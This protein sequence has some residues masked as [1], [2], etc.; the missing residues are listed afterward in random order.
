MMICFA[1][2]VGERAG[3]HTQDKKA[4]RQTGI[5]FSPN[6]S[7][8]GYQREELCHEVTHN[9]ENALSAQTV[10][11]KWHDVDKAARRKICATRAMHN[12]LRE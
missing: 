5:S 4:S 2:V 1:E 10:D 9:N 3:V 11:A 8:F 12:W 6:S 7:S